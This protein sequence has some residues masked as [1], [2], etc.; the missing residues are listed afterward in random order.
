MDRQSIQDHQL[1]ERYLQGKLSAPEEQAFEEAYLADSGLLDELILS[2]K[3]QQGLEDVAAGG[4]LAAGG[5]SG[6]GRIGGTRTGWRRVFRSPQYAA[7]ASVL[8][9]VSVIFSAL[10]LVQNL[11]LRESLGAG[12]VAM[13]RLVPLVTVRGEAANSVE[14]PAAGEWT[15]FLLDAGFTEYDDYRGTLVREAAPA[16]EPVWQLEG[17]SP[18][19]D[20]FIAFG[21]PGRLLVPGAY[22]IRLEGRMGDWPAERSFEPIARTPL[23][24]L[25][26]P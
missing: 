16:G 13:T 25:P 4:G 1:I 6:L 8:V 26:P 19:Y 14:A 7:A 9:G 22:Q 10:T 2:E 23:T 20:G 12:G 18:A 11:Q 5:R 21:L 15:V 3:L 24:I 17:L